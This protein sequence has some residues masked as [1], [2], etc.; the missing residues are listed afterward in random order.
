MHH[1]EI[2]HNFRG[3][4]SNREPPVRVRGASLP[5]S[6]SEGKFCG[7][8]ADPD[9][10]LSEAKSVAAVTLTQPFGKLRLTLNLLR[11][12]GHMNPNSPSR[13][14]WIFLL[15]LLISAWVAIVWL[16]VEVSTTTLAMIRYVVELA[17]LY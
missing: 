13:S 9:T 16:A 15:V 3:E 8:G 10:S 2:V 12:I 1:P 4:D 7:E 14:V 5:E 6:C 11:H 17:Q